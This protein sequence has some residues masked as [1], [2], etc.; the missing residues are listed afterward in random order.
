[1]IKTINAFNIKD[2]MYSIDEYGRV[3]NI[4]RQMIDSWLHL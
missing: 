4:A 3:M 1:M 2:N